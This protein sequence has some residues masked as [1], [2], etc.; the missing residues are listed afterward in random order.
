M[1]TKA[2]AENGGYKRLANQIQKHIRSNIHHNQE[3]LIPRI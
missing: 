2:K 3:E 1:K